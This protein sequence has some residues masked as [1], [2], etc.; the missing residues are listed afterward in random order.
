MTLATAY[1]ALFSISGRSPA[2]PRAAALQAAYE[3]DVE[4]T[5]LVAYRSAG[6]L[7]IIGAENEALECAAR[8]RHSVPC[9]VAALEPAAALSDLAREARDDATRVHLVRG[10]AGALAG[11]LGHFTFSLHLADGK[12]LSPAA[13]LRPEEPWFDLVLDLRREPGIAHEVAPFGYYAPRGEAE[14]LH[15]MLDAI[16]EMVGEFEKPKFFL[17]NPD[18]CAHGYGG[19]TGCTRCLEACPTGAIQSLGERVEVDPYLCQGAGTCTSVCP[20]GAMTYAYP[21]PRDQIRRLKR[22]LEAYRTAGGGTAVLLFHDEEGGFER[23]HELAPALPDHVL[24]V[25]VSEIGAVGMDT[26]LAALAYGASEIVLLDTPAVP[27]TVRDAMHDQLDYARV[28]LD[29]LGL[30]GERL[31]WLAAD[32]DPA[33]AFATAEPTAAVGTPAAFD[34]HNDKRG[35]LRLALDHLQKAAPEKPR[36]AALPA[37]APFG[38]IVVD[39][40]ACTLC[41]A[42]VQVCPTRALS[43]GGDM[44]RL[45][46]T[47]DVCVQCGLCAQ[48]C[49]E[50]AIA[51]TPRF[52]FDWEERRAPR[53]LNEEEPFNCIRCGTPFATH[54]VIDRMLDK[55][56]SH[57][58]FQ[59][60]EALRRLKMCGECRVVDMFSEDLADS[61][62]PRWLGPR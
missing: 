36:L 54:S 56:G 44:P 37:G 1:D 43:D 42:C 60:E 30:G 55:L 49:P 48:A 11:H 15:Q 6:N 47:E 16:P 45:S 31:T 61:P 19:L 9:T 25:A 24:P 59:S 34:T 23:M 8:L 12:E 20:S 22:M 7:L 3:V 5:S 4:P 53:V 10:A 58:M 29:A 28:L 26:W 40:Q 46:F 41:M 33:T 52:L 35:S 2:A 32:A 38:E 39:Q 21:G 14:R 17:Y 50:E 27:A 18:I 51:L 57:H 13:L 62:K